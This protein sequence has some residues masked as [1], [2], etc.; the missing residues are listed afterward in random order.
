MAD[1]AVHSPQSRRGEGKH[2]WI[3]GKEGYAAAQNNWKWNSEFYKKEELEE[4]SIY[5]LN[6][7]Q[8]I[9]TRANYFELQTVS[10]VG[11]LVKKSRDATAEK[12]K[13]GDIADKKCVTWLFEKVLN[14]Q[15]IWNW[16]APNKK[17]NLGAVEAK[18]LYLGGEGCTLL[19]M[20]NN[21]N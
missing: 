5:S 11:L 9:I 19:Y 6:H 8:Y 10:T 3:W 20:K 13:Q 21:R 15:K 1:H 14:Q 4:N 2:N 17:V 12:L 16:E 18:T 7:A